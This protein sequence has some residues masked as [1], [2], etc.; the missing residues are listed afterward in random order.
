MVEMCIMVKVD[1][2]LLTGVYIHKI[3]RLALHDAEID[4]ELVFCFLRLSEYT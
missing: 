2:E 1:W 3:Y 4:S